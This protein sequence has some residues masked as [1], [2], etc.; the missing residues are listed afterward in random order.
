[1]NDQTNGTPHPGGPPESEP[2]PI[3]ILE[4]A[5]H[6]AMLGHHISPLEPPR[7]VYSLPLLSQLEAKRLGKDEETAQQSVIALMRQIYKEHGG[8]A[9][10]FVDD[11]IRRPKPKPKSNIITPGGF[12]R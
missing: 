12:R 4:D 8:R 2:P 6:K 3:I 10:I 7:S 9:P 1:M 5:Y 11:A